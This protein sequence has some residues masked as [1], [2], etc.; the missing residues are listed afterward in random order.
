[1]ANAHQKKKISGRTARA[2]PRRAGQ[3]GRRQ[4]RPAAAQARTE[5]RRGNPR[6]VGERESNRNTDAQAT[7]QSGERFRNTYAPGG[8]GTQHGTERSAVNVGQ[9]F[10]SG[11]IVA[12]AMRSIL[13]ELVNLMQERMHQNFTRLLAFTFCRTPSQVITAQRDFIQ[14]NV[15]G[16]VRSAG[17][18]ADVS[19]QMGHEGVRRMSMVSLLPR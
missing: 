11:T 16:F 19:V 2:T 8:E 15:E 10:Q 6:S 3:K 9:V 7:K 12:S 13:Q 18:I 17:R 14:D 5:F 1:M 4:K